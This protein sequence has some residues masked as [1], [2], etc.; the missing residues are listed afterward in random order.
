MATK[1]AANQAKLTAEL[2]RIAPVLSDINANIRAIDGYTIED[3]ETMRQAIR[4]TMDKLYYEVNTELAIIA[5]YNKY[6][7][8]NEDVEVNPLWRT[9]VIRLNDVVL[10]LKYDTDNT[11][12]KT[13]FY[14]IFNDG[15][16]GGD[17]ASDEL[18]DLILELDLVDTHK[19]KAAPTEV[20]L[21]WYKRWIRKLGNTD[22]GLVPGAI[23]S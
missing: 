23:G 1:I 5:A 17:V 11:Y 15:M 18:Q 13:K 4:I 20:T 3:T 12:I 10:N 2:K 9:F 14:P 6:M 8:V 22:G 19:K 16:M 7:S 21:P